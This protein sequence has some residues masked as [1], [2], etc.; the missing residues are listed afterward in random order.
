MTYTHLP[1]SLPPPPF[2]P[3]LLSQIFFGHIIN[4]EDSFKKK[5]KGFPI[6]KFMMSKQF[7]RAFTCKFLLNLL[8]HFACSSFSTNI[9]LTILC[10]S[11]NKF[12]D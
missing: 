11:Y 12:L 7:S 10:L 4:T 1:P 3:S 9:G 2:L 6:R 8:N 5:K